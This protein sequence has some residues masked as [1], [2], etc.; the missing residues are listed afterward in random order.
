MQSLVDTTLS[1][2]IEE[3]LSAYRAGAQTLER[4]QEILQSRV[5]IYINE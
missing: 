5:F 1:S 2:I 3:E 4:T